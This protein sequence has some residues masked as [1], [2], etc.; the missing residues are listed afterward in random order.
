[1]LGHRVVACSLL[2]GTTKQLSQMVIPVTLPPE[3]H[4]SSSC[5]LSLLIFTVVSLFHCSH[6]SGYL[7]ALTGISLMTMCLAAF[8]IPSFVKCLF[9]SFAHFY[10]IVF[11]LLVCRSS[12]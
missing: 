12:L 8:V 10:W 3:I 1:M 7:I 11:F 5:S 6:S 2:V 9:K 4:E